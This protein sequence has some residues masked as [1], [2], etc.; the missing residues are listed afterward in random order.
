MS[1]RGIRRFIYCASSL[2]PVLYTKQARKFCAVLTYA[3]VEDTGKIDLKINRVVRAVELTSI[4]MACSLLS[5]RC[6]P[7][8]RNA[9]Q[10]YTQGD[11][12]TLSMLCYFR[13]RNL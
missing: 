10:H 4:R 2:L 1:A 13:N 7:A 12:A 9:G 8:T 3:F 6:L 11:A 5:A